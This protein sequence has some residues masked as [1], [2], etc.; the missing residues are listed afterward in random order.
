M[1]KAYHSNLTWKQ[2]ELIAGEFPS[3]KSGGHPLNVAIYAVVNA[4]L[5]VLCQ[6]CTWRGLPGDF[7][8]GKQLHYQ[9]KSA[10][11]VGRAH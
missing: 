2:W 8:L 5:Y 9:T 11:P 6:G 7:H 10:H 3:V 1:S 4:I